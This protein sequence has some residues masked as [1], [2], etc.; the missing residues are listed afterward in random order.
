MA[1][2]GGAGGGEAFFAI[3]SAWGFVVEHPDAITIAAA[4]EAASS[5]R[6]VPIGF[7]VTRAT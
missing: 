7:I 5:G 4:M 2:E 3:G 6:A 1:C